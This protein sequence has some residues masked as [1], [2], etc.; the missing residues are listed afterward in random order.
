MLKKY[1]FLWFP[2]VVI[3][4]LNAI[5]RQAIYTIYLDDLSA[6]Q[7]SVFSAILF[8]GIYLWFVSGKWKITS[9]RQSYQIGIMWLLMT[10]AFEFLFGHYVMGNSW[11]L[12]IHDY[13]LFEG[14]LWIVVLLWIT[15]SPPLFYCLR[16]REKD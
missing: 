16:I 12:L 14:R 7:L 6:H 4:I 5:I 1:F 15:L 2:M 8:F 11:E 3:A 9:S 13:N 10:I